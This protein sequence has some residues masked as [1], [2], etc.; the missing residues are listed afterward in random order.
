MRSFPGDA[1]R[2]ISAAVGH[3]TEQH[4]EPCGEEHERKDLVVGLPDLDDA[5]MASC[6]LSDQSRTTAPA[7][8]RRYQT[9]MFI[10]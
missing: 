8:A 4:K 6:Y 2:G 5:A 7:S 3:E 10:E 1:E 9:K